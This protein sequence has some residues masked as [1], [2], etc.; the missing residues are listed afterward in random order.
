MFVVYFFFLFFLCLAAAASA[1]PESH[2]HNI[3]ARPDYA[4]DRHHLLQNPRHPRDP[5]RVLR[6][7]LTQHTAVGRESHSWTFVQEVGESDTTS[8]VAF[9]IHRE[10]ANRFQKGT[11]G[12]S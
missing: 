12:A 11:V 2:S 1:A 10:H 4:A 8:A 5:Q 3:P 7:P 9:V 6:R